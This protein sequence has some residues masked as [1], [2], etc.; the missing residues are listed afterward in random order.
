M[1]IERQ[2]ESV[3]KSELEKEVGDFEIVSSWSPSDSGTVKGERDAEANG[4]IS[5]FIQ[6]RAH[7]SFSLPTVN[8]NGVVAIEARVEKCP[9]MSEVSEV[10]EKTLGKFDGW[11]SDTTGFSGLF[12]TADFYAT[13]LMLTGGSQITFDQSSRCWVLSLGF[14]IRGTVI[15]G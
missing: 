7:D 8:L 13:E 1:L 6:P 5:I 12:S 11:H 4:T 15:H 14:T 3:I 2:V 9:T 10:Y